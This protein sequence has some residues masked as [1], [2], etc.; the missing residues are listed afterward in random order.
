MPSFAQTNAH[1]ITYCFLQDDQDIKPR[2]AQA[3][4]WKKPVLIVP[5]LAS[6]FNN[7]ANRPVFTNIVR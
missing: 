6:E 1:V 7:S 4:R 3:A 2:L 5:A